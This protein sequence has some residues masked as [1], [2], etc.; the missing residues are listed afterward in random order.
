MTVG[1]LCLIVFLTICGFSIFRYALILW[2]NESK[3]E[4]LK[5][6]ENVEED[7]ESIKDVDLKGFKSKKKAV[8][9]F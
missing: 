6:I 2:K 9:D 3:K 1:R 4:K 8:N 5:D 7:F